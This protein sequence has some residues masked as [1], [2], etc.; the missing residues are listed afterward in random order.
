MREGP[1]VRIAI[2]G[3][4][5]REPPHSVRAPA[6][7]GFLEIRGERTRAG[8]AFFA[9][10]EGPDGCD[11]HR[12]A[13]I[14]AAARGVGESSLARL[15]LQHRPRDADPRVGGDFEALDRRRAQRERAELRVREV[16]LA[17][18]VAEFARA[19]EPA[20]EIPGE[21]LDPFAIPGRV[22]RAQDEDHAGRVVGAIEALA[23]EAREELLDGRI[24]RVDARLQERIDRERAQAGAFE[25][26]E[27]RIGQADDAGFALG[28]DREEV[29]HAAIDR[30]VDRV[31]GRRRGL[32]TGQDRES[33]R[34]TGRPE[35][36]ARHGGNLAL[37]AR[38]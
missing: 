22:E 3:E 16:A 36:E 13:G 38:R 32:R 23:A 10:R 35:R 29:R 2:D 17:G 37:R 12:A 25:E 30:D 20:E 15:V 18:R 28:V 19:R 9:D 21:A 11:G 31:L 26:L 24:P 27:A 7:H 4:M 8:Q 14:A 1:G 6:A 34:E 33:E 5:P